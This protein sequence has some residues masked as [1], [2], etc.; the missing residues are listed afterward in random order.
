MLINNPDNY[1]LLDL[2]CLADQRKGVF[3]AR[4]S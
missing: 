3:H 1:T 4:P 2:S